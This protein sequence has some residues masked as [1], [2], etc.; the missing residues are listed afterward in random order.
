MLRAYFR[1]CPACEAVGTVDALDELAALYLRPL[2][3]FQERIDEVEENAAFVQTLAHR[4]SLGDEAALRRL[5][6][7]GAPVLYDI[8]QALPALE[9]RR[10]L[11]ARLG[12]LGP[13]VAVEVRQ[14][15]AARGGGGLGAGARP[16]D[17]FAGAFYL[18]MPPDDAAVFLGSLGEAHDAAVAGALA[19]PRLAET[20][21]DAARERLRPRGL[22]AL[23]ALVEAVA[24][25]EEAGAVARAAELL[26]AW[27]RDAAYEI[28][29]RYLQA[30]LLGR[31]FKGGRKGAR[32]RV[33]ADVLA[34]SGLPAAAEILARAAAQERDDKLRSHYLAAKARAEG[35]DV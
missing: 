27:G 25:N 2:P 33:A 30:T 31:L 34:R 10:A 22:A 11:G 29:R 28:E 6:D 8:F 4:A 12:A 16:H 32:R 13:S 15:H 24:V 3:D 5:I 20:V 17:E 9:A 26:A 1:T 7:K 23:A 14:C 18:A 21:R 35:R 19:D